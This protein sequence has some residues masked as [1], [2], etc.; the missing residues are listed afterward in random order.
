[1]ATRKE[2]YVSHKECQKNRE[3]IFDK[4]MEEH[5][6]NEKQDARLTD[7]EKAIAVVQSQVGSIT[8]GV[9][10]IVSAVSGTLI[11]SILELILK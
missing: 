8:K 3:Q 11:T 1:M 9:W 7:A 4:L 2:T 6:K 10:A 5:T